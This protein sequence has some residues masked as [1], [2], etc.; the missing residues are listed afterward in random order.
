MLKTGVVPDVG[1]E[2]VSEKFN[3]WDRSGHDP[4]TNSLHNHLHRYDRTSSGR[5]GPSHFFKIQPFMVIPVMTRSV[6]C[7]CC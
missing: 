3:I 7:C 4:S 5:V 6:A 1:Q 2:T